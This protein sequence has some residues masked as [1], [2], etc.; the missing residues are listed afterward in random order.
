LIIGDGI[1][2]CGTP[3]AK[4]SSTVSVRVGD[5]DRG[6]LQKFNAGVLHDDCIRRNRPD[7]LGVESVANG[8]HQLKAFRFVAAAASL[9]KTFANQ[10]ALFPSTRR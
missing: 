9:W 10:S 1:A 5:A 7:L 2:T 3:W 4:P 6:L 8:K